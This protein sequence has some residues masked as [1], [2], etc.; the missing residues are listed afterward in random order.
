VLVS[1]S[2]ASGDPA[3]GPLAVAWAQAGVVLGSATAL[4]LT[5]MLIPAAVVI[6]WRRPAGA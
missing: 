2:G 5:S 4:G 3:G 6:R 1:L